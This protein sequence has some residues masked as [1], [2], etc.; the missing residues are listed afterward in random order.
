MTFLPIDPSK[1]CEEIVWRQKTCQGVHEQEIGRKT[2]S[3]I[4]D[5]TYHL[6]LAI[7]DLPTIDC[8]DHHDWGLRVCDSWYNLLPI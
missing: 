3:G 4:S 2:N 8:H 7:S 1:E 5:S 6:R